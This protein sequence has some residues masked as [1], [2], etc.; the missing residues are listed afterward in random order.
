MD[1]D[2]KKNP[3]TGITNKELEEIVSEGED[4]KEATKVKEQEEE[5]K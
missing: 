4:E 5:Y 3:Q 2:Q 1:N